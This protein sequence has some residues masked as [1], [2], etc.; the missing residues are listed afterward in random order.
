MKYNFSF[1]S[2][3]LEARDPIRH[4]Q[5][6]E[7]CTIDKSQQLHIYI[8]NNTYKIFPCQEKITFI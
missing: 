6:S 5:Y 3:R 2:E 8:K 1:I 4:A 7:R